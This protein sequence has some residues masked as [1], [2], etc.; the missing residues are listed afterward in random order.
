MENNAVLTCYIESMIENDVAIIVGSMPAFNHFLQAHVADSSM[1]RSLV[2]VL[3]SSRDRGS[4]NKS[5]RFNSS[6]PSSAKKPYALR[7]RPASEEGIE[8]A[9]AYGRPLESSVTNTYVD[10]SHAGTKLAGQE[11]GCIVR[12]VDV[13]QEVQYHPESTTTMV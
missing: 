1:W 3:R 11:E 8:L 9:G 5:S 7:S 4:T 6:W 2:S 12:T 13:V 10:G